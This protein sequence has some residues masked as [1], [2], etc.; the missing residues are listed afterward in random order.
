MR[1]VRTEATEQTQT[2]R[3]T[4]Y[5][6]SFSKSMSQDETF[7]GTSPA[8]L[9]SGL[10][11]ECADHRTRYRLPRS[12]TKIL[13][14]H[15]DIIFSQGKLALC[16]MASSSS[17]QLVASLGVE[18]WERERQTG[19]V[20]GRQGESRTS[21]HPHHCKFT[22]YSQPF[23]PAAQ[24]LPQWTTVCPA[25]SILSLPLLYW[26][27]LRL[28]VAFVL[29]HNRAQDPRFHWERRHKGG[30]NV[31]SQFENAAWAITIKIAILLGWVPQIP[32][33]PILHFVFW[34]CKLYGL[35]RRK[36]RNVHLAFS[37][38]IQVVWQ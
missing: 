32:M 29:I 34:S 1:R 37:C 19:T 14:C 25:L 27:P 16:D 23:T 4:L 35:E 30:E 21:P 6:H 7:L 8:T 2:F 20:A 33:R 15:R 12:V 17:V 11:T 10:E 36:A 18:G 28:V 31:S 13:G 22:T 26:R 9:M 24:F 38:A 5:V 3:E